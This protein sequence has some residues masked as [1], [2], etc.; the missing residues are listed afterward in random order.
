MRISDVHIHSYGCIRDLALNVDDYTVMVGPNGSG[1]SCVLYALDWFFNGG[2]LSA[3]DLYCTSCEPTDLECEVS[4]TI[5]VEVSFSNLSGEDKRVLEKYGRGDIARFRRSWS[6]ADGSVKMVGN[7]SQG[8]GFAEIRALSKVTEMRPLYKALRVLFPSLAD[9]SSKDDILA[10]LARW[11]SDSANLGQLMEVAG[12]DATHM[13]G[14]D[15][16]NTI[17]KR[18]RFVLIPAAA[19]IVGQVGSTGKASAVTRLV[20]ALMTEAA[21]AA[22]VKWE[23][24]HSAELASLAEA[25]KSGVEQSTRQQAARVNELF[26]SLVPNASIDLRPEVPT[27]SLKGDASVSTEVTIDGDRR[28]VARQGHGVQ[29]AVMMAMLQAA[30]PDEAMAKAAV[31][32]AGLDGDE[33]KSRLQ[34]ELARLPALIV[35][36]EEP[37]IYQHPVRARHFARV[38]STWAGKPTSQVIMATHSPYFV[39][40]E[41]FGALRRFRLKKG[42]SE[43]ATASI[44]DVAAAASVEQKRVEKTAEKELPRVFSEG[45][46]A[47]AAAFVEGD[48]DRV[49]VEALAER[50]GQAL[51][52]HGI[53]VL[54]MG[55]KDNLRVPYAILDQL[56]IR[57][58]VLA[59][60][61]A[62]G[63]GKRFPDDQVKQA[64]SHASHE[65][66]TNGLLA[67]LPSS[68]ALSGSLPFAF[69][70]PTVVTRH[71][72]LFHDDLEGELEAWPEF[73]AKLT[74][75]GTDVSSK[76]VA[77]Y[78]AAAREAGLHG[79]PKALS[80]IVEALADFPRL[81]RAGT[82]GTV[83]P[84]P[85]PHEVAHD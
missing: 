10:E 53:A 68:E 84:S 41:Q 34:E 35:G 62:R 1:K 46:F 33:G 66:S 45:F 65:K 9:V 31:A 56:G 72:G 67:W 55:G 60:A 6:S 15:G 70:D 24:E 85:V 57:V 30:V 16:P 28:D 23:E 8:P 18:V 29:R 69:G 2:S 71:W 73:V 59:D 13:F 37:E 27:W 47:E 63:A 79:V 17:A 76:N 44:N 3:D 40:P 58:Y 78:R 25:I 7:S 75:L 80:A 52:G 19:D 11:E 14:F 51:D 82:A 39:L 21:T 49:V 42:H 81:E 48:T 32:A 4:T 36:I 22:R 77:A 50:L 38:L 5:D 43:I 74:E 64:N 12:A 83:S 61:D 20:G 26:A 54:A